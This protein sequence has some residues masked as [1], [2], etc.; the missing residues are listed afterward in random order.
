VQKALPGFIATPGALL[1]RFLFRDEERLV[2]DRRKNAK[3]LNLQD[4]MPLQRRLAPNPPNSNF[5]PYIIA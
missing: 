5:T 4:S 1:F 2:Q 3:V